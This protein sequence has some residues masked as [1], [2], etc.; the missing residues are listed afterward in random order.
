MP[1]SVEIW[2]ELGHGNV[3]DRIA[4]ISWPHSIASNGRY[5]LLQWVDPWGDTVFNRLQ[6]VALIEEFAVAS[7]EYENADFLRVRAFAARVA[8]EVHSYLV[9]VGD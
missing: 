3:E 5:P 8:N 1:I 7:K 9:F 2:A 6:C 4:E